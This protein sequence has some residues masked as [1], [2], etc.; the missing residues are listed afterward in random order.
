MARGALLPLFP[1]ELVL[2]PGASLPLHIFEPRYRKMVADALNDQSEFG[3]VLVQGH[4]LARVGCT[5]EIVEVT[6]EYPDGR[7]D[8]EVRGNQRFAIRELD[9]SNPLLMGAVEFFEDEPGVTPSGDLERR[10]IALAR[11]LKGAD[12]TEE[13]EPDP[14]EPERLSYIIAGAV[15]VDAATR[16]KLLES[17][18]EGERLQMLCD[19]LDSQIEQG[20]ERDRARRISST[21]G[22]VRHVETSE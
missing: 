16:Q 12:D 13:W 14:D 10:A 4:S 11:Q 17:R 22:H 7:Y 9:Q 2:F 8:I 21:N 6:K 20:E 3:I 15:A 18:D 5:A 1:L 19:H